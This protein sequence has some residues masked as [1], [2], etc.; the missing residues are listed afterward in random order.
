[1]IIVRKHV[2]RCES[3]VINEAIQWFEGIFMRFAVVFQQL[4]GS[5]VLTEE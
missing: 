5:S 1:M 2:K 4:R 3:S